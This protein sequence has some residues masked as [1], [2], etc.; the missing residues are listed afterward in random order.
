M[1][2]RRLSRSYVTLHRQ[3]NI[4]GPEIGQVVGLDRMRI[5]VLGNAALHAASVTRGETISSQIS[6]FCWGIANRAV[7]IIGT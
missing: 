2:D 1:S 5:R 3:Q 4:G 7:K 6:R